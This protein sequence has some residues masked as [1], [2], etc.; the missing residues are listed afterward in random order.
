VTGTAP[1]RLSLLIDINVVLDVVLERAPWVGDATA[2]FDLVA[3]GQVPAY[4]AGH[5]VTTVHY[6]VERER[7]RRAATTAVGDLLTLFPVVPLD[8]ADV[9]RALALRL[10]DYEDAVQAVACLRIGADF[11]VTRNPKDF[12]GAPVTLRAPGEVL[13]L[14]AS[15][16]ID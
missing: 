12:R 4:I 14:I 2:L 10:R 5:T 11:L 3:R 8:T 7:D 6:I 1:R 13:A 16:A 15:T 9:Q